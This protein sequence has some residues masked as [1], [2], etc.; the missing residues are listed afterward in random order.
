MGS[1][2]PWPIL[3]L[4]RR[5]HYGGTE[6]QLAEIARSLDRSRFSPHIGCFIEDG[7]LGKDLRGSG[8]PIAEFPVRS[9]ASFSL[10]SGAFRMAQYIK[11]HGIAL[12]HTF[13]V[14]ANLFG[15]FAARAG[16]ARV[17]VSSQRAYRG[18]TPGVR[19]HLLRITDRIVDGVVV[20]CGAMRRHMID[21]E[22]APA[23]LIHLCYNS[24]DTG[25]FH[26]RPRWRPPELEG[27]SLVIGVAC[28][29]SPEKGLDTLIDA[30]A[31]VCGLDTGIRLLIVGDGESLPELE[32]RTRSLGIADRCVFLPPVS[33]IERWLQVFDIFV[34]PSISEALSNSLMEAMASGCCAIA[35]TAG[36]N[37]ELIQ[38]EETGLLFTPG[39][40]DGLADRLRR[41]IE[42][43][44]LRERLAQSGARSI[45]E[46]FSRKVCVAQVEQTYSRLLKDQTP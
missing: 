17:V 16:G 26:P 13:D 33:D 2:R 10:L 46:R 4:I 28:R 5:L 3:L 22:R 1:A 45:A 27:A 36:G 25:L 9:F 35:S 19:R 44:V 21:D 34:L 11:R 24:V 14:P 7:I 38:H 18:L 32:A 39:D 8:I 12:V 37:P 30:F 31:E 29:L 23:D 15:V 43:Q 41:V 40:A 6:R 20:N 42:D